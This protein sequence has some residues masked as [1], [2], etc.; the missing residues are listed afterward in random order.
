M[1]K[2]VSRLVTVSRTSPGFLFANEGKSNPK[3]DETSSKKN[4]DSEFGE[5]EALS[6]ADTSPP[7]LGATTKAEVEW[8]MD[9]SNELSSTMPKTQKDRFMVHNAGLYVD[10]LDGSDWTEYLR[11]EK[12]RKKREALALHWEEEANERDLRDALRKKGAED[13]KAVEEARKKVRRAAK[14]EQEEITFRE[15]NDAFFENYKNLIEMWKPME[16]NMKVYRD[17][18]R[19]QVFR[20]WEK[21][22]FIPSQ[23]EINRKV[24]EK[25]AD[26]TRPQLFN[27]QAKKE[28]EEAQR[29]G[30]WE[31]NLSSTIK[32]NSNGP[33]L[34][35]AERR[36]I[37]LTWKE[38]KDELWK[39][40]LAESNRKNKV[41]GCSGLFLD[42]IDE[43][44]YDP[45]AQRESDTIY[46]K[47]RTLPIGDVDQRRAE[48]EEIEAQ[49]TK[50][51]LSYRELEGKSSTGVL[52]DNP[53]PALPLRSQ[54]NNPCSQGVSHSISLPSSTQS[55][56][57]S[58]YAM[59]GTSP[60]SA[61]RG[62][63]SMTK[64]QPQIGSHR[65]SSPA[66]MT[67]WNSSCLPP[68]PPP[69][70]AYRFDTHKAHEVPHTRIPYDFAQVY[71]HRTIGSMLA[72]P[73][74]VPPGSFRPAATI[75]SS[76]RSHP[77]MDLPSHAGC[78]TAAG[79]K[80]AK[81]S[82]NAAQPLSSLYASGVSPNGMEKSSYRSHRTLK[83]SSGH[84]RKMDPSGD[85]HYGSIVSAP[86]RGEG[87]GGT[88]MTKLSGRCVPS[89]PV[90]ME[91]GT[92]PALVL[93]SVM[94]EDAAG[95][96]MDHM[97]STWQSAADAH[98]EEDR[99]RQQED[100]RQSP[101]ALEL[102]QKHQQP[103]YRAGEAGGDSRLRRANGENVLESKRCILPLPLLSTTLSKKASQKSRKEPQPWMTMDG[104]THAG[105]EF[106][107]MEDHES[108]GREH[109]LPVQRWGKSKLED[110]IFGYY[111]HSDGSLRPPLENKRHGGWKMHESNVLFDHYNFPTNNEVPHS[112]KR[113]CVYYQV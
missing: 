39:S 110:T 81:N 84:S 2:T 38:K 37:P 17:R 23:R 56:P 73:T 108:K 85:T 40:F 72:N 36:K 35:F 32:L 67:T 48:A 46:Y 106:V 4:A 44:E 9:N 69:P 55:P 41:G 52:R 99:R 77:S 103:D 82:D 34:S 98:R 12:R 31:S 91:N 25:C 63:S 86:E 83:D 45:I 43:L 76:S 13:A 50:L 88:G 104:T 92:R 65:H 22:V 24:E 49:Y 89:S 7:S 113:M 112:G 53:Q 11:A 51:A 54:R 96:L 18:V 95:K 105:G 16:R 27:R 1:S 15:R 14:E 68:S 74:L 8:D 30:S 19:E 21:E 42:V 90:S 79:T 87:D 29:K 97:R 102:L 57:T 75:C 3:D 60:S 59:P 111:V 94:G 26:G 64:G 71:E 47:R 58:A 5:L 101:M 78:S 93:T 109:Y 70:P 100:R 28:L 33:R 20:A 66:A 61:M 107:G 10:L 62:G 80:G 6:V